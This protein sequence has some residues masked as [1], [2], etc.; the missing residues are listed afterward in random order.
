MRRAWWSCWGEVGIGKTRLAEEFL[1]W[2]RARG[3]DVLEGGASEE[4]RLPYGP[5]VE[6]LRPRLERERAPDDLLEDAWLAELSRLLPELRERYSDL[7]PPASGE[8]GTAKGTLFEAIARTVG[9]LASKGA[10]VVLLLEDLQWADATTLEVL[11]YAGRRWAKQ[12]APILL[13]VAARLEGLGAGS[14]FERWL[15]TLGRRLPVR[16]LNLGPLRNEDLEGLLRR[17]AGVGSEPTGVLEVSEGLNEVDPRLE[18]FGE[19]LAAET[20]GQPFYLVETLKA[21]LEEGKLVVRA[22][23]DGGGVLVI[24]PA[25]QV[26]GDLSRLLPQSVREVIRSRISRL[27]PAASEL[28]A[29]GSVLGRGFGFETLLGVAYLEEAEGLRGLDELLGRRLLL[30]EGGG[31]EGGGRHCT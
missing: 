26:E 13:V 1:G 25:L 29:A 16:T 2:A 4:T 30:E 7:S 17:L 8:G 24:D 15:P 5:L 18:R 14:A 28:L 19:W 9:A 10:P 23:P 31:R 11:K 6:A 12:G 22:R 27:S 21:L 3:A 20:G